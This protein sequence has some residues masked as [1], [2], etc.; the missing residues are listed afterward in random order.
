MSFLKDNWG[1]SLLNSHRAR[2]HALKSNIHWKCHPRFA[3]VCISVHV[4]I[5]NINYIISSFCSSSVQHLQRCWDSLSW[6]IIVELASYFMP[7]IKYQVMIPWIAARLAVWLAH[8]LV[9]IYRSHFWS[10]KSLLP[11]L[12]SYFDK[13]LER[14]MKPLIEKWQYSI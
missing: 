9:F 12:D 14:A 3:F 5:S 10:T 1:F 13:V 2:Q 8:C 11:N 6:S 4:M 7:S